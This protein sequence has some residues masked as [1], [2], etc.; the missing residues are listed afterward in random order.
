MA[1][2]VLV[3]HGQT[4]ML[5]V[6]GNALTLRWFPSPGIHEARLRSDLFFQRRYGRLW[7]GSVEPRG[8][9]AVRSRA[10]TE[11]RVAEGGIKDKFS[12]ACAGRLAWHIFVKCPSIRG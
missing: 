3:G 4:L 12:A 1:R 8:G 7:R 6:H 2:V 9:E 5:W 11:S 10:P